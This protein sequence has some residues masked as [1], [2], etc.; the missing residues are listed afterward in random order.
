MSKAK[1]AVN[2]RKNRQKTDWV[3]FFRLCKQGKSNEDIAKAMGWHVDRKAG[4]RFK[5]VRAAK[6]VARTK[7]IRVH[8]KLV[9]L[10]DRKLKGT[11][12]WK[13]SR[14]KKV[15]SRPKTQPQRKHSNPQTGQEGAVSNPSNPEQ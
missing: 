11:D 4:D 12:K 9:R 14:K 1:K 7:G 5:R 8:G 13:L 3:L 10:R 2:H 6:S 15:N